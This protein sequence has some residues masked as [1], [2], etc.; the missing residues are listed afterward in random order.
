M[1]GQRH[2]SE[3][4]ATE[5]QQRNQLLYLKLHNAATEYLQGRLTQAQIANRHQV[6]YSTFRRYLRKNNLKLSDDQIVQRHSRA[7]L[8]GLT[9]RSHPGQS[10]RCEPDC[11]CKRH[12]NRR[13]RQRD[14]VTPTVVLGRRF[15]GDCKHWRHLVDFHVRDRDVNGEA[16]AW[17][18]ICMTCQRIRCR[19]VAGIK[20][21]GRPYEPRR[22]RLTHEQRLAR[23]RERYQEFRKNPVWLE[24]RREYERIY[25][26]ARRRESGIPR[27]E[28][29][30]ARRDPGPDAYIPV[31]P[32]SLWL[33]ERRPAYESWV[34]FAAACGLLTPDGKGDER[35]LSRYRGDEQESVT[36]G[37]VDR[38]L[39]HEGSM[40][41]VTL[42]S[43][44]IYKKDEAQLVLAA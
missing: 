6:A 11:G 44:N 21:R 8:K 19:Y 22:P 23:A 38:V 27:D 17:Q 12:R 18:S 37:F 15:C 30:I 24:M 33:E 2:A 32:F 4:T 41:I 43:G 1:S 16:I 39:Q 42:Y 34:D 10:H 36:A 14:S 13:R 25:A 28:V 20:R 26:E 29:R 7:A 5:A 31:E 3:S 35:R 40:T 9:K